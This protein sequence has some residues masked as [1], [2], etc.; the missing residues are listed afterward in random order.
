MTFFNT[1]T[2]V[3]SMEGAYSKWIHSGQST[4]SI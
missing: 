2:T 4:I 1:Q 3:P